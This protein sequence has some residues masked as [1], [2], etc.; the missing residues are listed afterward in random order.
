MIPVKI[1]FF[2]KTDTR[3]NDGQQNIIF[4]KAAIHPM[5]DLAHH[6]VD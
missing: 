3:N 4:G 1:L 2:I 6:F 5:V